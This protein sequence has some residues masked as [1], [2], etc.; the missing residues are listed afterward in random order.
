MREAMR[1][2]A[3]STN[4]VGFGGAIAGY[5]GGP[6][7]YHVWEAKDW[8]AFKGLRKLP[9]WVG[10]MGGTPEGWEAVQALY[11]L[12]ATPGCYTVLDM[13]AR[14]DKT[15]VEAFGSVLQYCGFKV[16]VYGSASTVF[17]NPK[18]NGY[19]VADYAGIGPFMYA[20]TSV[21]AT[22][23]A[24]GQTYDSSTV[25]SWTKYIGTWWR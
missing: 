14:V 16:W 3:F 21:R 19:W 10:G 17:G 15:Y 7:A 13:E 24:N 5:Y 22:Q 18:L 8:E 6:N 1:D 9:I 2:A 23:Y 20:H 25:K 12:G 11:A 4:L